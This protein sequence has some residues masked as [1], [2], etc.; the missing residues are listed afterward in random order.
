M[1]VTK[2]TAWAWYFFSSSRTFGV[3]SGSGP[4]SKVRT[5]LWSGIRRLVGPPG[6]RASMTG[7]PPRM[8]PGTWSVA[9]GG[10]PGGRRRS[11]CARSRVRPACRRAR[12]AAAAAGDSAW[13]P[14]AGRFSSSTGRLLRS[15]TAPE[16]ARSR[17]RRGWDRP[18][19]WH[20]GATG[21]RSRGPGRDLGP[22]TGDTGGGLDGPSGSRRHAQLLRP[23]GADADRHTARHGG[24]RLRHSRIRALRGYGNVP[25]SHDRCR[26]DRR[27]GRLGRG[28]D[29]HPVGL[30]PGG[31]ARDRQPGCG[32]TAA[33]DRAEQQHRV[34]GAAEGDE[35]A[36]TAVLPASAPA[37]VDEDG[38][39]GSVGERAP[40]TGTAFAGTA[41]A[42]TV[43]AGTFRRT[44][45]FPPRAVPLNR[46]VG[47]LTQ[48][49]QLT[50]L[51]QLPETG[52]I[53]PFI[54]RCTH[55]PPEA[56]SPTRH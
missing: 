43:F 42:G 51:I 50:Q 13:A 2:K 48:L 12:R 35:P 1:P 40:L 44:G 4:S 32:G 18:R 5:I 46:H 24:P 8:R 52:T 21:R 11:R 26:G 38:A 55:I 6:A 7:P 22:V 53:S 17:C 9:A 33:D 45:Q 54:H 31:R 15:R 10:G 47:Q 25:A 19:G 14:C 37:H 41:F 16:R 27:P 49:M 56:D 30:L 39:V 29:P 20:R 3:H 36:D 34:T 23:G 28:R